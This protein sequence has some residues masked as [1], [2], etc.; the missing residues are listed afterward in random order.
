MTQTLSFI[1][2]YYE[3]HLVDLNGRV[4]FN[5]VDPCEYCF[6]DDGRTPL[7]K[8]EIKSCIDDYIQYEF[9]RYACGDQ[10]LCPNLALLVKPD[11][12]PDNASEIMAQSLYDYYAH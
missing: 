9:D 3:W 11:E 5:L 8:D 10:E 1:P 4:L 6:K 7:T 2:A 12:L